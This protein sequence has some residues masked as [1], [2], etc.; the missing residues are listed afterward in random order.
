MQKIKTLSHV[1]VRPEPIMSGAS[2]YLKLHIIASQMERLE[3]TKE[4]CL[5]KIDM[6]NQRLELLE[7]RYNNLKNLL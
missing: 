4:S 5:N 2:I 7:N 1:Y 6:A 3:N